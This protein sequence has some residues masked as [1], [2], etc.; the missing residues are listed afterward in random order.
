MGGSQNC[1]YLVDAS[2]RVV[3]IAC[4][5]RR[6]RIDFADRRK[7][8]SWARA[9]VHSFITKLASHFPAVPPPLFKWRIILDHDMTNHANRL[10]E[11]YLLR[12]LLLSPSKWKRFYTPLNPRHCA[13]GSA[14]RVSG[15]GDTITPR[16]L[17][18][19]LDYRIAT[20]YSVALKG[21]L[22]PPAIKQNRLR[23]SMQVRA[24]VMLYLA[25][26]K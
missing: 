22:P 9:S 21:I 24:T 10:P 4:S 18:G 25:L 8:T 12:R 16:Q 14:P 26:W 6:L 15:Y 13:A 7:M 11:I 20:G 23:A 1:G 5:S 3:L 19:D 17:Q 2:S